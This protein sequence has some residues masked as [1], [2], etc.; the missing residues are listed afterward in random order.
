MKDKK[1]KQ[2]IYIN[3]YI[4]LYI[5]IYIYILCLSFLH[6]VTKSPLTR[7]IK[8]NFEMEKE[9]KTFLRSFLFTRFN[10]VSK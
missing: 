8:D 1:D 7:E 5:Y 6:F 4:Y 3:I 9:K 10:L 2:H